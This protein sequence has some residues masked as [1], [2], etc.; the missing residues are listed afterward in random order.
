M[1][2][3][4]IVE[5]DRNLNQGLCLALEDQELQI[6]PCS[7]LKSA[8][9]QLADGAADLVLLDITLP[10]GSGL[11]LLSDIKTGEEPTPVIL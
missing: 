6:V 11:E 4:I 9:K 10:D 1:K 3:V 5:D 8:R 7:D 2:R